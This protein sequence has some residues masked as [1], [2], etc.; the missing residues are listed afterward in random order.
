[1]K[2]VP[3]E[4]GSRFGEIFVDVTVACPHGAALFERLEKGVKKGPHDGRWL[5]RDMIQ[6]RPE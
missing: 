6:A 4:E 2:F 1:V 5:C 3:A